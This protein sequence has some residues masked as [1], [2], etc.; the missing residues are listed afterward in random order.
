MN[1]VTT[2]ALSIVL[3]SPLSLDECIHRL[4][5]DFRTDVQQHL[6]DPLLPTAGI[7]FLAAAG[8]GGL[9]VDV[10]LATRGGAWVALFLGGWCSVVLVAYLFFRQRPLLRGDVY[11]SPTRTDV[12]ISG[13]LTQELLRLE[14]VNTSR[15]RARGS[16]YFE[17]SLKPYGSLTRIEGCY[18]VPR[19]LLWFNRLALTFGGLL[20]T[21][22]LTG[23]FIGNG[24]EA[25]IPLVGIRMETGS[26]IVVALELV[27]AATVIIIAVKQ[28]RDWKTGYVEEQRDCVQYL[29]QLLDAYP[30][31]SSSKTST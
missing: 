7:A 20:A 25:I 1:L 22:F 26:I 3:E 6:V 24:Q 31:Y 21:V 13:R 18:G 4:H 2:D 5:T 27:L 14:H 16:R 8:F 15:G 23:E 17:G 12:R 28:A 10:Q 29:T 9:A 11:W 19:G 30:V